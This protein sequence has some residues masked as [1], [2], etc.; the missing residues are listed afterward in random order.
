MKINKTCDLNFKIENKLKESYKNYI[1]KNKN[2]INEYENIS[3]LK[4]VVEEIANWH[5]WHTEVYSEYLKKEQLL[6]LAYE[7]KKILLDV[8]DMN[9]LMAKL[10]IIMSEK[11]K[12]LFNKNDEFKRNVMY[13]SML[14]I[15]EIGGKDKGSEYA[16]IFAKA[17]NFDYG[18]T[19][20]YASYSGSMT[21]PRLIKFIE[22]YLNLGGSTKVYWLPNYFDEKDRYNMEE[23]E[24]II[25]V[26]KELNKVQ[27]TYKKR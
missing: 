27:K 16:L 13:I 3:I 9:K 17:F 8:F 18:V 5:I 22:T 21:D 4:R 2:S 12:D 25:K 26:N 11:I 23:L 20:Q 6:D 10:D 14:R 15:I 7:D 24:Y 1:E 19:M